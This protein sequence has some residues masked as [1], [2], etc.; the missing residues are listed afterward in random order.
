MIWSVGYKP[1]VFELGHDAL[2]EIILKPNFVR[3]I[4]FFHHNTLDKD[5]L[6][7]FSHLRSVCN[8]FIYV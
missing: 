4:E 6:N 3:I 7:S 5:N 1:C 8:A 2:P